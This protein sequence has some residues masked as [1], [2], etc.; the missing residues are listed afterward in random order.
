MVKSGL[1][2]QIIHDNAVP[3][4][5]QYRLAAHLGAAFLFYIGCMKFG[6]AIRRDAV[7]AKGGL[8]S[9]MGDGFLALLNNPAVRKFKRAGGL[10][11][12]LVFLTAISGAFVAGLDAGLVYN[13][14]PY[15]GDGIVPP[16]DE[17][18]SPSYA[19]S[20]DK[21]DIW[22]NFFENPTT[23]QFDHRVL[24]TTT[25]AATA[26]LYAA[27]FLPALK[28][29]LPI[30]TRRLALLSFAVANLQ[31][32]LGITTLLYLV[33]VPIAAAHQAGSVALLTAVLALMG[34]LRKPSAAA[35]A[36]R[37]ARKLPVAQYIRPTAKN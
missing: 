3:R 5:S 22:R 25:Y 29:V 16:K 7:W 24:G 18:L 27:T 9:G 23:V 6:L 11:F 35:R 4:V 21:S 13:E 12:T 36:L 8:V 15:M 17:L 2:E 26:F 30:I 10:L 14:F 31:V 28:Q 32:A 34:S 1:E 19:K 37:P 20:A 33:P